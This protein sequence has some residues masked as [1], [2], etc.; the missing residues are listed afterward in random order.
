MDNCNKKVMRSPYEGENI[1]LLRVS[2]T[3]RRV[4]AIGATDHHGDEEIWFR[5]S[6]GSELGTGGSGGSARLSGTGARVTP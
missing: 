3:D 1:L 5:Q 6:N 2:K 4:S